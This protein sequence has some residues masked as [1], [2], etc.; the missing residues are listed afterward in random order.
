MPKCYSVRQLKIKD[1]GETKYFIGSLSTGTR[2]FSEIIRKVENFM[3]EA[4]RGMVHTVMDSMVK[5]IKE[6][7]LEGYKVEMGPFQFEM[8]LNGVVENEQR[9][10]D[11][12]VHEVKVKCRVDDDFLFYLKK[13]LVVE[14]VSVGNYDPIL[15]KFTNTTAPTE[16]YQIAPNQLIEFIGKNLKFNVASPDEGLVLI[17]SSTLAETKLAEVPV[18]TASKLVAKIPPDLP[19]GT[20]KVE[21]RTKQK[22]KLKMGSFAHSL[23][24]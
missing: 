9:G 10:F 23:N 18:N 22:E 24:L 1:S 2:D 16:N 17:Q 19:P 12:N 15:S 11:S 20:Y 3:P 8:V 4:Q 7:L 21:L 5:V 14:K 13:Q 6:E